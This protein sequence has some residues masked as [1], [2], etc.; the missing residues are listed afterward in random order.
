M[1]KEEI[2]YINNLGYY[3]TLTIISQKDGLY[4]MSISYRGEVVSFERNCTEERVKDFRKKILNNK[5]M[6]AIKNRQVIIILE[7]RKIMRFYFTDYYELDE[8]T[9][10]KMVDRLKNGWDFEALFDDYVGSDP[11]AYLIYDEVKAY[12]EKILKS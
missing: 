4:F 9:I 8:G 5:K 3:K 1:I 12:I 11:Q 6:L 10:N 2:E 7:R